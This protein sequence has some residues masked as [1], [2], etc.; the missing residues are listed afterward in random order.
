MIDVFH[1]PKCSRE[2]HASGIATSDAGEIPIFQCDHCTTEVAAFGDT[3]KVNFTF[4][5]NEDGTWFEPARDG[6]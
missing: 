2:L 6:L 4:A 3:F 5:V 1:C